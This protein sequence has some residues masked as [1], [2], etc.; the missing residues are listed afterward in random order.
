VVFLPA[1]AADPAA[2]GKKVGGMKKALLGAAGVAVAVV[3][4]MQATSSAGTPLRLNTTTLVGTDG[5]F[6]RAVAQTQ[7]AIAG[8]QAVVTPDYAIGEAIVVTPVT[9]AVAAAA[10][11]AGGDL[12]AIVL[13]DDLARVIV[14]N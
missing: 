14:T 9:E 3:L 11:D 5:L 1:R 4:G 13:V 7:V 2:G 6:T 10:A 8:A 12:D